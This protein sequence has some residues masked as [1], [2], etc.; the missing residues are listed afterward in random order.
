MPA[1]SQSPIRIG[2]FGAGAWSHVHLFH[3]K[4]QPGVE[5]TAV[6]GLNPEKVRAFATEAGSRCQIIPSPEEMLPLVDA[7]YV[8]IPPFASRAFI[9]K[10]LEAG[11]H[12]FCEKPLARTL[13]EGKE[14]A[15]AASRH[16][17]VVTQ[18]GFQWRFGTAAATLRQ[19][20]PWRG[21]PVMFDGRYCCNSLH[22]PWWRD[23]ERSGGQLLEQVIHILD[24]AIHLFGPVASVQAERANLCHGN[25]EG[26]TADD[27]G[28]YLLR[29]ANGALGTLASTNQAIPGQWEAQVRVVFERMVADFTDPNQ[30]NC[31]RTDATPPNTWSLQPGPDP[32]SE[33]TADF[34]AAIRAGRP[35]RVPLGEGLATLCVIAA[36]ERALAVGCSMQVQN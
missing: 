4:R 33:E 23:A 6:S 29:F 12:V 35:A 9:P 24:F 30:G 2:F 31:W 36:I 14:L 3:L 5:V 8:V 21:R 13:A 32:Y 34:L 19:A 1:V 11:R 27:V 7:V 26:Y 10:A 16:P 22:A 18:L 28:A 15:A 25:V 17:E 20:E